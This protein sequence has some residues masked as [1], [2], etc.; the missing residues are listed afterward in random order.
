ML[1]GSFY[2]TLY[3]S[4]KNMLTYINVESNDECKGVI[5]SQQWG[6]SD[7]EP[8]R[9]NTPAALVVRYLYT[10]NHGLACYQVDF[11]KVK[12]F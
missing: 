11:S 2:F 1:S 12:E 6:T 3:T 4:F 7:P 9:N 8:S 5:V 10:R